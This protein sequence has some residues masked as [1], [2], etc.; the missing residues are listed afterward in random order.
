MYYLLCSLFDRLS[1]LVLR[2]QDWNTD[3]M[4]RSVAAVTESSELCRS[5]TQDDEFFSFMA[6]PISS[7]SSISEVGSHLND[8]FAKFSSLHKYL[9][10]KKLFIKCS[11]PLP[12]S[13]PVEQL[14]ALV[15]RYL[16]VAVIASLTFILTAVLSVSISRLRITYSIYLSDQWPFWRQRWVSFYSKWSFQSKF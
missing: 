10:I 9:N 13:T 3:Y 15:A 14:I 6:H 11:T 12:S 7:N 4:S 2:P 8:P 16:C 1:Y 5:D